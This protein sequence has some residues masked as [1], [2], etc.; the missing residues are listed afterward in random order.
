MRSIDRLNERERR[1]KES[2][3]ATR[4][5]RWMPLNSSKG[6]LSRNDDSRGAYAHLEQSLVAPEG[7]LPTTTAIV[8]KLLILERSQ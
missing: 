3:K 5:F 2:E 7:V 8:S 6:M 4:I 1:H